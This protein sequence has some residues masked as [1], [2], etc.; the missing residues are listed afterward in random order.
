MRQELQR[1]RIPLLVGGSL[2][3]LVL[4]VYLAWISPEGS[5]LSTLNQSKVGLAAQ[6]TA[7]QAKIDALKATQQQLPAHC[8]QL[9]KDL[10]A[11]PGGTNQSSF[12]IGVTSLAQQYNITLP[13]TTPPTPGPVTSGPGGL[14]EEPFSI[15][16]A[17]SYGNVESF[18]N[19][20]DSLARLY[21]ITTIGFTRAADSNGTIT[22][23]GSGGVGSGTTGTTV[24]AVIT[25]GTPISSSASLY[26]ITLTGDIYYT[27]NQ[28]YLCSTTTTVGG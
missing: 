21:T 14:D 17:G 8:A 16:A 6:Q 9:Q 23:S 28:Q 15:V 12:L 4:V 22:P 24:P 2:L 25:G 1:Y 5:K 26:S 10:Q 19:G 20:L 11:I 13:S 7:L 3:V 18:L 27:T